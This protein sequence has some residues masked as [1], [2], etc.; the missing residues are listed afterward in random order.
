MESVLIRSIANTLQYI[1]NANCIGQYN[2]L[3]IYKSIGIA[4][5]IDCLKSSPIVL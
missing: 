3:Q 5:Q 4:I 2:A 1:A